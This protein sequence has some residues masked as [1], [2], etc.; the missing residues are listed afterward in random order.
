MDFPC[1]SFGLL[2]GSSAMMRSLRLLAIVLV[3]V[4]A[5]FAVVG[6]ANNGALGGSGFYAGLDELLKRASAVREIASPE[7]QRE[8][9]AS[10]PANPTT[11]PVLR[12]DDHMSEA[13]IVEE[14]VRT[15]A[16]AGFENVFNYEFDTPGELESVAGKAKP[17]VSN[18]L[19]KIEH[20][21]DDYVRNARPIEIVT[22]DVGEIVVRARATKGKHFSLG[23]SPKAQPEM[24]WRW[25]VD[26]PL[27]ADGEFH[28]YSINARNALRRGLDEGKELH[29]LALQPS[30]VPG[31]R[32][33]V[34]FIRFLSTHSKYLRRPRDLAY[35]S[36][37]GEMR[38]VMSMLPRQT[39]EFSAHIPDQDPRLSFGTAVS[40]K[41]SRIRFGVQVVSGTKATELHNETIDD[42]AAWHDANYDLKQWAGQEVALRL[43]VDGDVGSVGLWSSPV[44]YGR[45][46]QPLRVVIV[47]EDALRA[48]HLSL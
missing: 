47:L 40:G 19:L 17:T 44:V 23:W 45:P 18:G 20:V 8:A 12:L 46:A 29:F 43:S 3:V 28:N 1:P 14:P 31:D 38:P 35:E 10:L 4:V 6:V 22:D 39:L 9:L 34:D 7:Y 13:R 30:D 11:G 26:I 37:A 21:H 15:D 27:I 36:I 33:E 48:D 42:P 2:V 41:G 5:L 32:V 24:P 16:Y 25:R